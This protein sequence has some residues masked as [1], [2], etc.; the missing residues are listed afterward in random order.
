MIGTRLA[1]WPMDV[2][3]VPAGSYG[4]D[5]SGVWRATTP[6]G[7]LANLSKHVVTEYNDG[8]ITVA[9]SILVTDGQGHSWHGYLTRGTWSSC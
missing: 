7:L 9:P 6:N 5:P 4:P 2:Y 3:D 8:T 1:T